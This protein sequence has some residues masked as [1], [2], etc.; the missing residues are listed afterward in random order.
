M[1]CPFQAVDFIIMLRVTPT[2]PHLPLK[3]VLSL[4]IQGEKKNFET[5]ARLYL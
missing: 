1:K 2:H 3:P 5:Y 4:D